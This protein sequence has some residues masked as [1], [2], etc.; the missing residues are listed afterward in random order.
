MIVNFPGS[1][2]GVDEGMDTLLPGLLHAFAM[3]DG[4]GH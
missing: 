1:M 2:R 3:M 4:G